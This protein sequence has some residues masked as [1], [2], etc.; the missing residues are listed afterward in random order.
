MGD[1]DDTVTH[2]SGAFN[3]AIAADGYDVKIIAG[4]G[5]S[6]TL[7]STYLAE[8]NS[9]IV[10]CYLNGTP[11]PELTDD[12]KPLAPLKLV[13]PY[14][15]GGQK[16]GNIARIEL[17][18]A[19]APPQ[20]D[21]TLIGSETKV[22]SLDEVKAMPAYTASGGFKKSTGVIVGPYTYTGVNLTYLTDLVSLHIYW[23]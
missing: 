9:Y 8:N 6:S 20:A 12:G 23:R 5:Y 16:V 4:D 11:L 3:D 17:D 21:L 18:V 10:A 13:G 22:Y 14:L 7:D 2:G 1:V 19:V 15:S